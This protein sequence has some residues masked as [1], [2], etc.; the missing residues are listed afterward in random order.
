MAR[1]EQWDR[2]TTVIE[3][4]GSLQEALAAA[5]ETGRLVAVGFLFPYLRR[6]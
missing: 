4:Q 6:L 5:A 3:W 1:P 2:G